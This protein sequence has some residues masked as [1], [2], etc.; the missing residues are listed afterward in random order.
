MCGQVFKLVRL[1]NE[2]SAE[3]DYYMSNFNKL[4]WEDLGEHDI[5]TNMS[6]TKADTHFEHTLIEQPENSVYSLISS[7][8]H[9]R[10]L[11]DPAY[12]MQL[13]T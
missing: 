3:M 7:D 1:R 11:T 12:R 2:F 10:V 9:D 6:L 8:E 4:W 5:T 13:Q